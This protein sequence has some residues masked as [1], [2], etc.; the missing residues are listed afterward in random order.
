MYNSVRKTISRTATTI[1]G[2]IFVPKAL[3]LNKIDIYYYF[4]PKFYIEAVRK[5]SSDPSVLSITAL[6][7][8]ILK[9]EDASNLA[10]KLNLKFTFFAN[11]LSLLNT[12][13]ALKEIR[14]AIAKLHAN[15]AEINRRKYII[16]V[17]PTYPK[18]IDPINPH[19]KVILSYATTL[20]SYTLDVAIK[21]RLGVTYKE[22]VKAFYSF[23]YDLTLSSLPTI[24]NM[25][26]KLVPYD[27]ILYRSNFPYILLLIYLAFL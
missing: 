9:G 8:Y 24:L 23:H 12:K 2:F 26:L 16:F 20:L 1:I 10:Y 18:D 5:A 7:A 19:Y 11:L 14:Y 27:H 17:Y 13:A 3:E 22:M 6:G 15:S 25:L 21:V 4:V